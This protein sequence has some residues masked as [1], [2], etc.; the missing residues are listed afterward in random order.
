MERKKNS[1][2]TVLQALEKARACCAYQERCAQDMRGKLFDWGMRGPDAEGIIAQLIVEGFLNEE[3]YA[4]AFAGGKFRINKWGRRKIV[5]ALKQK[6]I[7]S[8]CI[9]R[10]LAVIDEGDYY[11]TIRQLIRK[12]SAEIKEPHY[13]KK[14]AKIINYMISKGFEGELVG[15]LLAG[16]SE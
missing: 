14:K 5:Q 9:Q 10:G 12:K 13:L 1:S 11:D 7:S 4:K 2:L 16:D 15:R 8:V 3:R 6:N